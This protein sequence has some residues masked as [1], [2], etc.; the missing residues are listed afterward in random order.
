MPSNFPGAIDS[1][2]D[3]L[4]NSPLN[5]PSHSTLHS[6]I[7]DAVEKVETYMGL[8]KVIPTSVSSAGGT[9]ATLAA[10]GT[11]TIGTNNTSITVNGAFSSLYQ[12]YLIRYSITTQS[13]NAYVHYSQ[14]LSTGSNYYTLGQEMGWTSTTI[15]GIGTTSTVNQVGR[16]Q[17]GFSVVAGMVTV[18][19]PNNAVRTFGEFWCAAG[20]YGTHGQL[21]IAVDAADTAF[22]L[23]PS[24]GNWTGGTITVYGYRN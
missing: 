20:A 9:A 1:F 2:T 24:A 13:A 7:N 8:V 11:V 19:N 22:T 17:S 3:P 10:N 12:S 21:Q 18:T 6:D 23:A 4:S 5:S 16:Y 14:N 15:T